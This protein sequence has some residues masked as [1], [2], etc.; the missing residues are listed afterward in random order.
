MSKMTVSQ[1][2]QLDCRDENS[3]EIIQQTLKTIKPLSI[4]S[5]EEMVPFEKVEKLVNVLSKKYNIRIRDISPDV[6]S[7][8]KEI[9]WQA[10]IINDGDLAMVK[11][12]FGLSVYEAFAKAAICMYHVREDVGLRR[13]ENS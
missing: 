12:I 11:K 5:P 8:R 1:I 2:L 9:I 7:N 13:D 3:K 6:W 4:Y 10:V